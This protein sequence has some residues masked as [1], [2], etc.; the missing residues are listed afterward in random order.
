MHRVIRSLAVRRAAASLNPT[1]PLSAPAAISAASSNQRHFNV[2][3]NQSAK[4]LRFGSDARTE[5]LKGVDALADA[6]AVTL[7]PKGR[8][9][10]IEQSWGAPKITKVSRPLILWARVMFDT[11]DN[12]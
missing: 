6:V 12:V 4:D 9:V 11:D 5:M 2:S 3:A 1:A 10:I 7:G 8:N